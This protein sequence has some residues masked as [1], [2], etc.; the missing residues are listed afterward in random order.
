G[1]PSLIWHP[2]HDQSGRK[3]HRHRSTLRG[4]TPRR[5]Q[6]AGRGAGHGLPGLQIRPDGDGPLL[7]GLHLRLHRLVRGARGRRQGS[8]LP[9]H[10]L[11]TIGCWRN[12]IGSSSARQADKVPGGGVRTLVVFVILGVSILGVSSFAQQA[13]ITSIVGR[14]TDPSGASVPNASVTAV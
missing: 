6:A 8:L 10:E 3:D 5:R 2:D 11:L 1:G 14:V 12:Y 4:T 13:S 9:Q 7:P